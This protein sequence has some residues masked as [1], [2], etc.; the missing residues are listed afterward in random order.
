LKLSHAEIRMSAYLSLA[1]PYVL[2]N[3]RRGTLCTKNWRYGNCDTP[4]F[5]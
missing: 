3:L 1:F 4:Y 5:I 2:G